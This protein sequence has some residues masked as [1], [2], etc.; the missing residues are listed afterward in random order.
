MHH[1]RSN[2][3]DIVLKVR[4]TEKQYEEGKK[5]ATREGYQFATWA[6]EELLKV[7]MEDEQTIK[8]NNQLKRVA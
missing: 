1:D 4:F 5:K 6:H 2:V 8:Q 3:R 7:L